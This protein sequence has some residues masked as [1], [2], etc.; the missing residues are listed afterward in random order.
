MS[1]CP[2]EQRR[3]SF[4]S[5]L[6]G[7]LP[8]SGFSV[9]LTH[10]IMAIGVTG[11]VALLVVGGIYQA[12]NLSQE[13]SRASATSARAIFDLNKQLSIEMLEARRAEKNFQTRHNESYAKTHAEL[14]GVIN[15]DFDKQFAMMT[16]QGLGALAEKTKA[17]HESFKSY[18]ADFAGLVSAETRLGLNETLGLSGSLRSAA[19]E[20]E[21]KL[22]QIDDARLTNG[23]STMR[24]H[25]KDF[26][27]RRD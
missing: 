7:E 17:A 4:S 10:K 22:K 6:S 21:S 14:V 9:R 20:V 23:F 13:A 2:P 26:M 27:L 5:S 12:G 19:H 3:T 11:L 18:A 24:R 16:A 1:D 15:R 8:M 25:E